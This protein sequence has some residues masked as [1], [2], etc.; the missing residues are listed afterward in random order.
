MDPLKRIAQIEGRKTVNNIKDTGF[1]EIEASRG[2]SAHVIETEDF[3]IASIEE[4]L[5]TKCLVADD[6]RKIT[7]KTYYDSIAQDTVAMMVNDIATVGARPVT[8]LAYWAAGS[9]EWFEDKDKVRDLVKGWRRACDLSGATWGGGET[10]TL[11]GIIEPHAVDL[12]GACIGL[13]KPK[14]RLTLG[15]KL[16]VGDAIILFESNG[17]HANGLSLARKIA[18]RLP[19]GYATEIEKGTLYG[20]AL[21][22][23]TLIYAEVIQKL[24]ERK[25]DIH[26]IVNIT[27][28]GWRKIMRHRK[29]FTYRIDKLPPVPPVLG[30]IQEQANLD[31]EQAY[32]TFNMGA[33]YAVF[34]PAE[35][36]EKVVEVATK[37]GIK[38][39]IAGKV[40]NGEKQIV[41][42]PMEIVYKEESLQLRG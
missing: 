2:E 12:A 14:D 7:G 32:G 36:A 1:K 19:E 3:Y 40:E 38:A 37:N 18:D 42:E 21:L 39:L 34:V 6:T 25:I 29:P 10:P 33:G 24:F 27:G 9:S 16:Q 22:K 8:I 23:P 28:H 13:I 41:I 11:T 15:Q 31:N 4:C 35:Q 20:E 26:Y 17:I 5:G 30:F